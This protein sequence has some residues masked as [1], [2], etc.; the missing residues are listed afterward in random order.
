MK[1]FV[2]RARDSRN[3]LIKEYIDART[4][5]Q[6]RE[7]FE[8]RYPDLRIETVILKCYSY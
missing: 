7:I 3:G 6:A 8:N 5:S 4:A 2:I 1:T